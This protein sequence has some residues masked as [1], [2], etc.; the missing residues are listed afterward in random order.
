[1]LHMTIDNP[2][3]CDEAAVAST[4]TELVRTTGRTETVAT[5]PTVPTDV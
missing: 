5:D 4:T 2:D 3:Q 1:M